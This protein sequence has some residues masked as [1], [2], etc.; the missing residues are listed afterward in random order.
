[1]EAGTGV[2][3][4]PD[5]LTP[6]RLRAA[7]REAIALRPNARRVAA[8]LAAADPGGAFADAVGRLIRPTVVPVE[9]QS[10]QPNRHGG[11]RCW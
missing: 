11:L 6:E 1:M 4:K 10:H 9:G 5:E 3:V 8:Q 2:R 7:V